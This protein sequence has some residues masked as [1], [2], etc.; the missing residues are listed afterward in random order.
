MLRAQLTALSLSPPAAPLRRPP[1]DALSL[2]HRTNSLTVGAG[3]WG[4]IGRT[5]LV[6]LLEPCW[7]MLEQLLTVQTAKPPVSQLSPRH[8]EYSVRTWTLSFPVFGARVDRARPKPP[9][10]GP[11]TSNRS[12]ATD[13]AACRNAS[14]TP[15]EALTPQARSSRSARV[16]KPGSADPLLTLDTAPSGVELPLMACACVAGHVSLCVWAFTALSLVFK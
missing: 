13:H 11:Q 14:V 4:T 3:S 1:E 10:T 12:R 8:R 7:L 6:Q 5:A 16:V 9:V 15:I 2:T